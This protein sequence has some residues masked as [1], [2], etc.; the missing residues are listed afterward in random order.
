MYRF[1]YFS[2][3]DEVYDRART[4]THGSQ[5][6]TYYHAGFKKHKVVQMNFQ[7]PGLKTRS[8]SNVYGTALCPESVSTLRHSLV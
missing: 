4:T 5:L 6:L 7:S 3:F 1:C 2:K 8:D